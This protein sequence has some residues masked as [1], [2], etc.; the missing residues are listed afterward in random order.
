ME[1][2]AQSCIV[3][4]MYYYIKKTD[5]EAQ[6]AL[7]AVFYSNPL[8]TI[9]ILEDSFIES[10]Y[11]FDGLSS[12]PNLTHEFI[13]KHSD[14]QWNFQKLSS[15]PCLTLEM[16]D[17]DF[18]EYDYSLVSSN[19]SLTIE[20]YLKNPN[21]FNH[22]NLMTNPAMNLE[23]LKVIDIDK[24]D[25]NILSSNQNLTYDIVEYFSNA[26]WNM[27][28][29]SQHMKLKL[30]LINTFKNTLIFDYLILNKTFIGEM[31]ESY[32]KEDFT[33]QQWTLISANPGIKMADIISHPE[34]SWNVMG[35]SRNPNI[36]EQMITKFGTDKQWD[37][38][39]L[40]NNPG[41]TIDI[42]KMFSDDFWQ[43]CWGDITKNPGIQAVDIIENDLPW[44]SENISSNPNLDISHIKLPFPNQYQIN[45]EDVLQHSHQK[46]FSRLIKNFAR[47]N[48]FK[49]KIK[50]ISR[51]RTV[52]PQE[53]ET[54]ISV[55]SMVRLHDT[56]K[57]KFDKIMTQ[58][59]KVSGGRSDGGLYCEILDALNN[60]KKKKA[61]I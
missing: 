31:L 39:Q 19:P 4:K 2:F 22:Q 3:R 13:T 16:L 56:D 7:M 59:F 9:E 15:N 29:V 57:A 46:L 8:L 28:Q 49:K 12:N 24:I 42:V 11:N 61:R 6:E 25:F 20:M 55:E 27:E 10:E 60:R 47:H 14:K 30:D 36:T 54:T 51:G 44:V 38:F 52:V 32:Q 23:F 5:A 58:V 53:T 40:A 35:L 17:I 41:L 21:V 48:T 33:T 1:Q 34:Y 50:K 43:D 26:V 18:I 45:L 37:A